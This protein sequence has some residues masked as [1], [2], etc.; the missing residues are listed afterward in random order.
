[1][2]PNPGGQKHTGTDPTDLDPQHCF[3]VYRQWFVPSPFYGIGS[4]DL[5]VVFRLGKQNDVSP[6]Y[7]REKYSQT[8]PDV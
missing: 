6:R 7:I 3:K 2:D 5:Q 1:M 4:H 8:I